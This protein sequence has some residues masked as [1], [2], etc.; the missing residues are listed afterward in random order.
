M[1]AVAIGTA[2]G[3]ILGL[4]GVQIAR[5]NPGLGP[6]WYAWGVAVTG[7]PCCWLGG[8]LYFRTHPRSH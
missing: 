4:V 8:I 2:L 3:G 1:R 5:N 6:I 7:P